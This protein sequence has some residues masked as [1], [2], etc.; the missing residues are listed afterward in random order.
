MKRLLV[1]ILSLSSLVL[2]AQQSAHYSQYSF[3]NYGYNPAFA[4]TQK[5][6]DFRLGTRLQWLGFEGAPVSTFAWGHTQIGR[7]HYKGGGVHGVGAYIE[8]DDVHLTTRTTVKLGYAYHTKL[9]S[10]YRLGMGI[11][12]GIQQYSTDDVFGGETNPD[13]V[14]A[15]AAGSVLRYPDIMPGLLL[16]SKSTY[17]SFSVNQLYFKNINLGQEE[18]QVNQYYFGAGHKSV[19][20]HW[21]VFKS[22]LLKQNVMGPPALDL[23]M[24]W[25]YYEKLTFGLGYRVGESAI[26]MIKFN[27]GKIGIGYAFDF[28][29]NK[30]Y[31]N[32]GHEIMISFKKCD[33]GGIGD[34]SGGK[35]HVCPAYN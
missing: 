7:K 35:V 11:F 28:P 17:W 23:N 1:A 25:V 4:G 19:L 22:F 26:G 29:L 12:A 16:Y 15:S 21:T 30:L 6:L 34:G 20:G 33:G 10:K 13:P 8:Q 31:G 14:L 2:S 5:C 18:K 9:S 24:A 32:Y 27:L 3:N